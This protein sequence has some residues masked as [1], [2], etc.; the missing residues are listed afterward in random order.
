[1]LSAG[2]NPRKFGAEE[3][4]AWVYI[5]LSGVLTEK[6]VLFTTKALTLRVDTDATIIVIMGINNKDD[7]P[8][9]I[10]NVH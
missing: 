7:L 5:Q 2:A 1:M 3:I 8:V 4:L 9:I 10:E 6:Y